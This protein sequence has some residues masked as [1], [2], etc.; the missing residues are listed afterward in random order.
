VVSR[1]RRRVNVFI[2]RSLATTVPSGSIVPVFQ[3]LCHNIHI[4]VFYASWAILVRVV[5]K[6]APQ[7]IQGILDS[8]MCVPT[9]P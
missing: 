7:K 6:K 4:R 1:V 9:V 2:G 5:F 3:L 8:G